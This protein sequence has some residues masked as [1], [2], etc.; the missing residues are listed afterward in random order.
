MCVGALFTI[1]K[2]W[3]QPKCLLTPERVHKVWSLH[4][5]GYYSALKGRTPCHMLQARIIGNHDL[6]VLREI[7]SPGKTEVLGCHYTRC[8]EQSASWKQQAE[9]VEIRCRQREYM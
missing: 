5:V 1:T 9:R 3:K 2:K 7:S 6:I 8:L 4:T